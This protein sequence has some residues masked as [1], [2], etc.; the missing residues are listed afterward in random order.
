MNNAEAKFIL[1]A[2]RPNGADDQHPTMRPALDHAQRDPELAAWLAA[3]TRFD[4]AVAAGLQTITPPAD[5]R[6]MILTGLAAQPAPRAW[7]RSPAILGLAAALAVACLLGAFG[8][9]R[10]QT[11]PTTPTW[12]ASPQLNA[13]RDL[14]RHETQGM[15]A[16]GVKAMMLGE[17]GRWLET[18]GQRLTV[19]LPLDFAALHKIGCRT[20]NV[21]GLDVIEICFQRDQQYHLYIARRSDF[22]TPGK[23]RPPTF[24]QQ[25]GISTAEWMHGDLICLVTTAGDSAA[26]KQIL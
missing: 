23:S 12:V 18:P 1:H 10:W 3:Q 14:A 9:V 21:A 15:H 20:L 5:L 13:L 22:S 25:D 2:R 19:G 11:A 16:A 8:V 17:F 24:A 7:W 4:T 6:A 26:L